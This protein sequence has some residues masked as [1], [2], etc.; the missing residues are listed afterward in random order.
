[1]AH[2]VFISYSSR[3]K[4]IADAVCSTLEAQRIRCWIAP[5]DI[6]PGD[7]WGA[8]I[9]AAIADADVLVLV[10]TSQANLSDHVMHEVERAV[11]KG[12]P[13]VPLRM[14]AVSPSRNLELFISAAHWLDALTPPL[15]HHLDRL[16][17][18]VRCLI[19]RRTE[20]AAP[21]AVAQTPADVLR[22]YH[23]ALALIESGRHAETVN[24]L[25]ELEQ[26]QLFPMLALAGAPIP[27]GDGY[28]HLARA[29]EFNA[30]GVL[31]G[32]GTDLPR[33]LRCCELALENQ[34]SMVAEACLDAALVCDVLA[35]R[36]EALRYIERGL[37]DKPWW[38]Q[39][40][41][42]KAVI[43]CNL[44]DWATAVPV[45]EKTLSLNPDDFFAMYNLGLALGNLAQK[46]RAIASF[47]KFVD[48]ASGDRGFPSHM[49]DLLVSARTELNRLR[50]QP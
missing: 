30:Q 7:N 26:C 19:E 5:R 44:G 32:P 42:A 38:Y 35:R 14:E 33:V 27:V 34:T 18:T 22:R 21:R 6:L 28:Y 15:Q 31:R 1:M 43:L 11:A 40:H 49:A 4:R 48:R 25:E 8:A 36:D 29:L 37:A 20:A 13:V 39:L 2:N 45:L 10:F 50:Y 12:I 3:D 23:E 41:G 16:C 47:Q 24:I 17:S 46:E 9:V